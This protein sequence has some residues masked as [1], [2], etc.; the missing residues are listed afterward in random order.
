MIK[1]TLV[2]IL[3][4]FVC[5]PLYRRKLLLTCN[6]LHMKT[7]LRF[8]GFMVLCVFKC[9]F[10]ADSSETEREETIGETVYK[11]LSYV[12]DGHA[13]Q[14][15]DLYLPEGK[16]PFPVLVWIHGGAWRA[17]SKDRARGLD[18]LNRGV[19]VASVNY[20]LS[21]HATFP[22][23]IEDCKVPCGGCGPMPNLSPGRRSVLG[24]VPQQAAIWS[25]YSA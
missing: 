21:Q 15:L 9:A 7:R 6:A 11:D 2:S 5:R 19:A 18:W 1:G 8:W 4:P 17:G 22:A 23:Q 16:G 25:P 10:R 20:R 3:Q 24:G 13:R 12:S 14:K